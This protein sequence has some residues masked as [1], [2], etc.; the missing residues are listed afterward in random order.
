MKFSYNWLSEYLEKKIKPEEMVDL[1]TMHAFEVESVDKIGTDFVLDIKILPNRAH[2]CMSHLGIAKE[3]AAIS[4]NKFIPPKMKFSEDKKLKAEDFILVEVPAKD[5]CPRYSMRVATDIK[6]GESPKWMQER[7]SVCGLR[8][9][10]NIVDITNYVMLET[11]QPLHAFDVDKVGGKKI[12]VRRAGEGEKITTLEGKS[13]NLSPKNLVIADEKVAIGIAGIKGGE[14]PEI[15]E[16]TKIVAI[17]SANFEPTNIRRTSKSFNLRTDASTR[18]ENGLDPE[19][20]ATALER[21]VS[22]I[23][24]FAGGRVA[25]GMIDVY[26]EK[27]K[28][29]KILADTEWIQGLIDLPIKAQEMADILR[30]FEIFAKTIKKGKKIFIEA[31]VPTNRLDLEAQEDLAEEIA[32]AL[33]Y[34][35]IPSQTPHGIIIPALK[36]ELLVYEDKIKDILVGAGW[37]EAQNYS[38]ISDEDIKIFKINNQVQIK[39]PFSQDQK[40]LRPALIINL[41]KNIRENLKYFDKIRLFE[42]GHVFA[43]TG[44]DF[45][46]ENKISAVVSAKNAKKP[47]EGLF[48]LKGLIQVLFDKLGIDDVWFDDEISGKFSWLEFVHLSRRAQV[49]SGDEI[50]GWV[51][52]IRPEIS[53]A[54]GIKEKSSVF[55]LDFAALVHLATEERTYLP[56]SKYPAIMRDLAIVVEQTT[57]TESVLNVI[58]IAGGELLQD[59]DLFDIYEGLAGAKKSLA[60]RLTFQSDERNLTDEEVN[61]MMMSIIRAIEEEGW[62]VR[63]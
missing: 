10:S 43:K 42:L 25:R 49:K 24:E 33:G 57:K 31:A 50:V 63:K 28:T 34:D 22:L 7:L 11:G 3:L 30:K 17:E 51:G 53:D 45:K 2:D 18:F 58:E 5:L 14:G 39:N 6:I 9:I 36:D 15:D 47:A 40:Y 27:V 23:E 55:E 1:L 29:R 37:S 59:T 44:K 41:L 13:Y 54:M 35:K 56:P 20:T 16:K 38:F 48:E 32:R 61:K 12:I 46:E 62:E 21:S 8:P 19:L 60:F 4:G 26:L 52:E